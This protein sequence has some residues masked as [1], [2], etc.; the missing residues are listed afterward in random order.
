MQDCS[1]CS[2]QQADEATSRIDQIADAALRRFARYGY[3]RSSMDDIAK[4]AGLAKATLYLHFKSKDD[5]FRAMLARLGT[6]VE[7]RCRE[8]M[9]QEA[10]FPAKLAALLQ[11]HFCTAFAAFGDGDHLVELKAVMADVA[12]REIEAFEAVFAGFATAL[13][14]QAESAGEITLSRA[15]LQRDALVAALMLAAIGAKSGTMP[16]RDVYSAR[17]R[18]LA[19]VFSA[20]LVA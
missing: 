10:P 13:L 7:A 19:S 5:I 2:G 9:A 8:A 11:A 14:A 1:D 4:E 3:R 18:D 20:A 16:S 12:S 6:R 15:G 17:L